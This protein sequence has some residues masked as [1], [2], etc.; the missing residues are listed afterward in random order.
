MIPSDQNTEPKS[1]RK[2]GLDRLKNHQFKQQLAS[3]PP[4]VRE[5]YDQAKNAP[6]GMKQVAMRAV[7]NNAIQRKPDGKYEVSTRHPMFQKTT[8]KTEERSRK[9]ALGGQSIL[10]III[11][12]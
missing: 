3:L 5:K 9:D 4:C 8:S 12:S 2:G 6:A 1:V 11:H 10:L 7:I